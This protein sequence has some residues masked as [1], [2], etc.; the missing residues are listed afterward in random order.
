MISVKIIIA[1]TDRIF[2]SDLMSNSR[3]RINVEARMAVAYRLRHRYKYSLEKIGRILGKGHAT[4][5]YYLKTHEGLFMYDQPYFD[6]YSALVKRTNKNKRWLCME[7]EFAVK[8][9][10][11]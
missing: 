2:E 3:H 10:K 9:S 5:I 8:R 1:E 7:S 6:K 11:C 4:I